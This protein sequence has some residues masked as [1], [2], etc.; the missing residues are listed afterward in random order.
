MEKQQVRDQGEGM[1][2]EHYLTSGGL[3]FQ[4]RCEERKVKL[5]GKKLR[6]KEKVM[7]FQ[8]LWEYR[9]SFQ[10]LSS[11]SLTLPVS[12]RGF[13]SAAELHHSTCSLFADSSPAGP[14]EE[15]PQGFHG[16]EATH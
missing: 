8:W 15:N 7:I 2:T 14:W 6:G 12:L 13:D 9:A 3:M 5:K 11:S 1:E 16:P 4:L 10:H